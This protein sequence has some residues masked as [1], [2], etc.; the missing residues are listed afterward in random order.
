[1]ARPFKIYSNASGVAIGVVLTQDK[2]VVAYESRKMYEVEQR[3]PIFDQEL[4]A[5]IHAI[6]TWKRYLKNNL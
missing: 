4:L 2:K 3:Y 6:K 5:I 1:M